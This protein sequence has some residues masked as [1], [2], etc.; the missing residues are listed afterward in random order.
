[1][2]P[3][4][5]YLL[6]EL[7]S[8]LIELHIVKFLERAFI[9]Q[10]ADKSKA[11]SVVEGLFDGKADF[12]SD[13]RVSWLRTEAV[14]QI[15]LSSQRPTIFINESKREISQYPIEVREVI[16]TFSFEVFT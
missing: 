8:Q 15:L 6:N 14:L 13:F 5:Y 16:I 1:M 9:S 2:F 11:V 4:I 10:G 3:E 12:I 7:W